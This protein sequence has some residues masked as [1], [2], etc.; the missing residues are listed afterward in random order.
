MDSLISFSLL[1]KGEG[2]FFPFP[3]LH[4]FSEMLKHL[5]ASKQGQTTN[6]WVL[7]RIFFFSSSPLLPELCSCRTERSEAVNGTFSPW[8]RNSL[9][10]SWL[11]LEGPYS[12][13]DLITSWWNDVGPWHWGMM[14]WALTCHQKKY[15]LPAAGTALQGDFCSLH[16]DLRVGRALMPFI[17]PH[18]DHQDHWCAGELDAV[19]VLAAPQPCGV[20]GR[21]GCALK[22]GAA[23]RAVGL[24]TK[25]CSAS[26]SVLLPAP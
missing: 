12:G 11:D 22:G 3:F 18:W 21:S 20:G 26:S 4:L 13:A 6:T 9:W 8:I 23:H 16:A 15:K 24:C 5:A 10:L 25:P 19:W 17:P 7:G 1:V 2:D 14:S